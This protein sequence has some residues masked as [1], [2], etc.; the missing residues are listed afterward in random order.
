MTKEQLQ[1]L[2]MLSRI[3]LS[4]IFIIFI[5]GCTIKTTQVNKYPDNSVEYNIE[6]K[7]LAISSFIKFRTKNSKC[8]KNAIHENY[9]LSSPYEIRIYLTT[10][11]Q[12]IS[13]KR[14]ENG[15]YISTENK[16]SQ[17]MYANLIYRATK[18][19]KYWNKN[20]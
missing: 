4:L 7:H 11:C 2:N 3:I 14:Y 10:N 17:N 5:S 15:I 19:V 20:E 1:R 8:Y 16:N 6:Y 9:Q 18:D 13:A 12:V